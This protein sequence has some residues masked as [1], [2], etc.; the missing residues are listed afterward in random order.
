MLINIY[1]H[2]LTEVTKE[3][4]RI[5]VLDDTRDVSS[6]IK[7]ALEKKENIEQ[8]DIKSTHIMIQ[9]G[10]WR[11]SKLVYTTFFS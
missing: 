6:R 10:Y 5:L 8:R 2:Y 9:C 1:Y 4:R 11:I 3:A 7:I